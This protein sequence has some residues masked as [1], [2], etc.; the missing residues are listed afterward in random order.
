MVSFL[1]YFKETTGSTSEGAGRGCE[2]Y[3]GITTS[4]YRS[5]GFA[6]S[7]FSGQSSCQLGQHLASS[8][9][10]ILVLC[11]GGAC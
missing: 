10:H 1:K 7:S 8:L 4:S 9:K 6:G 2:V 3:C 5:K 11:G